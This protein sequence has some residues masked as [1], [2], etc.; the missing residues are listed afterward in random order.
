MTLKIQDKKLLGRNCILDNFI[1]RENLNHRG[2]F[3]DKGSGS[4]IFADIDKKLVFF[5]FFQHLIFRRLFQKVLQK[6]DVFFNFL[7][8]RYNYIIST[9]TKLNVKSILTCISVSNKYYL[10]TNCSHL[11]GLHQDTLM[12]FKG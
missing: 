11:L 8:Y 7:T 1:Y 9:L 5:N 12:Y 3:V 6:V 4:G 10:K 2:L